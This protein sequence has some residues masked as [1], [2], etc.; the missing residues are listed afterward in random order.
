MTSP[1]RLYRSHSTGFL[2]E[3]HTDRWRCFALCE[4]PSAENLRT[5]TLEWCVKRAT[6][7]SWGR[8]EGKV[9]TCGKTAKVGHGD[10]GPGNTKKCIRLM[11]LD[12]KYS[13]LPP[14][15]SKRVISFFPFSCLYVNLVH[16]NFLVKLGNVSIKTFNIIAKMNVRC[17]IF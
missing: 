15:P 4:S 17:Y 16:L 2:C 11:L 3:L 6:T 9:E 7:E 12:M 10:T 5:T 13:K 14:G 8:E 1:S